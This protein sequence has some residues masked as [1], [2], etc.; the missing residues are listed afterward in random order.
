MTDA[1][2]EIVGRDHVRIDARSLQQFSN[3]LF[4]WPRGRTCR[5]VIAPGTPEETV[6]VVRAASAQGCAIICRGSGFSYNG[7]YVPY[8]DESVILDMRRLDRV[9]EINAA[10]QYVTVEAGCTWET[11]SRAL[12]AT[13][14]RPTFRPSHA[15]GVATIGGSLSNGP[16]E[17]TTGVLSVEVVIGTG[18]MIHTGSAA[19]PAHPSPFLRQFGPDLTGMFI[20]DGGTFGVKT[21]VTLA[22]EP[23]PRALRHAS[24]EFE[25]FE[26]T[27]RALVA[28]C[29]LRLPGRIMA[30]DPHRDRNTLHLGCL[31]ALEAWAKNPHADV[32]LPTRTK[33]A[34][35]AAAAGRDF[36][37]DM[38]WSLHLTTEGMSERAAD[39]ALDLLAEYCEKEGKEISNLLPMALAAQPY[40]VRGW[41]HAEGER[42][43]SSNAIIPLSSGE[44][45]A[46]RV[47]QFFG[48]HRAQMQSHGIAESYII[49]ARPGAIVLDVALSWREDDPPLPGA[50]EHAEA[51]Q[52]RES[53]AESPQTQRLVAAEVCE[54]LRA[55]FAD[56]GA[57]HVEIA[58][59]YAY[60]S[61]LAP[62]FADAWDRIRRALDPDGRLNPGNLDR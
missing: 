18:K 53:R 7:G 1:F 60:R 59:A 50:S 38:Q 2:V 26:A 61:A 51:P 6:R 22:L 62:Q 44:N 30:I 21:A 19:R 14:L 13:S 16:T 55:L 47:R 10:D 58:K 48:N 31:E 52:P 45:V 28:C 49:T 56:L 34:L 11:L 15:N 41:L 12:E 17:D 46:T 29:R 35:A 25:T 3:D 27:M 24:F 33:R 39:D 36:M 23:M 42:R 9:R 5:A 4:Y 37:K 8:Q 20:G 40:S 54:Q 32:K 43:V 57:A